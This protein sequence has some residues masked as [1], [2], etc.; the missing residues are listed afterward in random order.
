MKDQSNAI[1]NVLYDDGT[2]QVT[3][4]LLS[5]PRRF[6]PI[7]NITARIRRD[8]LWLAVAIAAFTGAT[9]LI[10]GDLL[11]AGELALI[12]T[13]TAI[14]WGLGLGTA[15]LHVDAFGHE[16]AMLFASSKTVK[17]I[18]AALREAKTKAHGIEDIV[19]WEDPGFD[20]E[21]PF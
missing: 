18:F 6:Y 7:Q 9:T 10:Y 12:W 19:V 11:Y 2:Y 4:F 16:N 17:A 21:I 1:K 13:V 14:A 8:P 5:T 20:D 15:F 3:T